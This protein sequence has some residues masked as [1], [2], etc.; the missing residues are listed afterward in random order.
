MAPSQAERCR[1]MGLAQ[2]WIHPFFLIPLSYLKFEESEKI[3]TACVFDSGRVLIN[4]KFA[5]TCTDRQ[6]AG[7]VCH[8]IMHLMLQ[9]SNRRG[10]REQARWNVATDLAI[11][12]ALRQMG[13]ELPDGALYPPNNDGSTAEEFYELLPQ[14]PQMKPAAGKVGAGCGVE[15]DPNGQPGAGE[16]EGEPN[17]GSGQGGV[18]W[19]VVA[20]QAQASARGTKSAEALAPLLSRKESAIRWRQLLRSTVNRIAAS[21]GRDMQT[22]T[23]RNRRS[24]GNVILPGWVSTKPTICI[25]VDTS[26]SMSDKMLEHAVA[27]ARA[28]GESVG[29]R[30]YVA[31][32]DARCYWHGW[33]DVK[34][35]P[36][37]LAGKM[38]HRGGT[39]ATDTYTTIGG[40]R[41]KFDAMIHLTDGELGSW[42]E[43]PSNVRRLIVAVIG[44][45]RYM[46]QPP[47]RATVVK[48]ECG[49]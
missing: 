44:S 32:H 22:M 38:T 26:G 37:K 35:A 31:L 23:R 29:A 9:H 33:L 49:E 5:A 28:A 40:E 18:D 46:T 47:T 11:N 4:P 19:E 1:E 21:G 13:I 48:V 12:A 15:K 34:G 20:H 7:V 25:A 43:I 39:D 3:P 41:Q 14:M 27:E 2:G 45:G 42:P 30:V 8:E 10:S 16:G 17:E 6:L 36:G 24:P